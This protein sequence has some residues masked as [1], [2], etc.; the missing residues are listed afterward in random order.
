M[1]GVPMLDASL[2]LTQEVEAALLGQVS[3]V[4]NQVCDRSLVP[5]RFWKTATASAAQAMCPAL[6]II[7]INPEP[8]CKTRGTQGLTEDHPTG[9]LAVAAEQNC[10]GI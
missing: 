7:P 8:Q 3:E 10:R 5:H 4:A 6:S 2:Y 9:A 1:F